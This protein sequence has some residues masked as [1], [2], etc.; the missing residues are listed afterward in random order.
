MKRAFWAGLLMVVTLFLEN[1]LNA[2]PLQGLEDHPQQVF[3]EYRVENYIVYSTDDINIILGKE[4]DIKKL[5]SSDYDMYENV[6]KPYYLVMK[7][8]SGDW[9]IN[10]Y[11][12]KKRT[13][14]YS[15]ERYYNQCKAE[16]ER[17]A[18]ERERYRKEKEKNK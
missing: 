1:R 10:Y 13:A 7:L 8:P 15:S 6:S 17:I 2:E 12:G 18:A 11:N 14:Y 16:E 3:V 5:K 9:A 4:I